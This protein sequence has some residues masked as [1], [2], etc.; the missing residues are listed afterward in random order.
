MPYWMLDVVYDACASPDKEKLSVP[1][2]AHGEA[3]GVAPETYWAT[4]EGFLGKHMG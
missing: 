1:G 3:S 4:V 2:A